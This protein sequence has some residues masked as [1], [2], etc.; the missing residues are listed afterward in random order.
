MSREQVLIDFY[1]KYDICTETDL[2]GAYYMH[3]PLLMFQSP[4]FPQFSQLENW[5]FNNIG[6]LEEILS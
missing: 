5:M 4:T 1:N 2:F 6:R 3:D